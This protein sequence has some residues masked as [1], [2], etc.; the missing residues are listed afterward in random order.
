WRVARPGTPGA[1]GRAHTVRAV[2]GTEKWTCIG[3]SLGMMDVVR[4]RDERRLI[5]HLGPEILAPDFAQVGVFEA[6][7]RLARLS[8]QPLS[9]ALLDQRVVAGIGTIWMA[10]SLYQLRLW[11]WTLVADTDKAMRLTLLNIAASRIANSVELATSHGFSAVPCYVYGQLGKPC[12][13][14][15]TRIKIA[16]QS[17]PTTKPDQGTGERIVHWCPTCQPNPTSPPGG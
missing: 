1:A 5:G 11:P 8:D 16:G 3:E 9:R 10:E 15:G 17:G 6:E 4:T 13:R 2:L 14:C 12:T 7:Q